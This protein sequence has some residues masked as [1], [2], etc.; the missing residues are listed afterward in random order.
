MV[1]PALRQSTITVRIEVTTLTHFQEIMY[2]VKDFSGLTKNSLGLCVKQIFLY[3]L[4]EFHES[5]TMF[6]GAGRVQV[7]DLSRKHCMRRSSNLEHGN[8]LRICLE[9]EEN[10]ENLCEDGR[11][12]VLPDAY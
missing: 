12:Q 1:R 5:I 8:H 11:S 9:T 7:T 3:E 6:I 4:S 10:R 2:T